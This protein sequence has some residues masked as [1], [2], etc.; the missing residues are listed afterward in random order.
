MSKLYLTDRC[1]QHAAIFMAHLLVQ[2]GSCAVARRQVDASFR[3]LLSYNRP[4]WRQ[5]LAGCLGSAVAGVIMPIF[6]LAISSILAIFY[7][8]DPGVLKREVR[9]WCV[10]QCDL[11]SYL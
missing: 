3:R 7:V 8:P 5:A 10:S 2:H 9:K 1:L 4:E 6:A 11:C